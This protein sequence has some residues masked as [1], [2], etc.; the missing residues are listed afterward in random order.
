MFY[1][2]EPVQSLDNYNIVQ[3]ACGIS[4]SIA[5]NEW[6]QAYAWG[7]NTVG[8]LG[9]ENINYHQTLPKIIKEISTKHIVQIACG[10]FHSLCLTNNGELYSW[11]S[12]KYGQLGLG[13]ESDVVAK[14]TLISSLAGIPFA[15]ITCG[16]NHSFA[17]TK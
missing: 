12:N 9:I 17:V 10:D 1:F 14:P 3:L 13:Y 8:Q 2:Q 7:S 5:I 6:G 15:F 16:S 4:H 11:G